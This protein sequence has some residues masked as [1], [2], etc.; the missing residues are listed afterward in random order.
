M[1]E[2]QRGELQGISGVDWLCADARASIRNDV[3]LKM[4]AAELLATGHVNRV[5]K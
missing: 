1:L 2:H 5:R 4:R 3:P